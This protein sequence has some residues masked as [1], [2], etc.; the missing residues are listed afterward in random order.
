M[1]S[2]S[3]IGDG[4]T[5][6]KHNVKKSVTLTI[7]LLLSAHILLFYALPLKILVFVFIA[8]AI[9]FVFIGGHNAMLVTLP[10]AIATLMLGGFL[11]LGFVDL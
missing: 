7:A 9:F 4:M 3:Y 10:L 8:V 2:A 11:N 6:M 5:L 1:E